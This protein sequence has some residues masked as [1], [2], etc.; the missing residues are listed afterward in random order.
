MT[1]Q[2]IFN[3]VYTHLYKQAQPAL[4][5]SDF[6]DGPAC[7]YRGED[8]AMCA[9]GCLIPDD[10]YTPEI[11]GVGV[12]RLVAREHLVDDTTANGLS[13]ALERSGID[14]YDDSTVGLLVELQGAHDL[15]LFDFGL[16]AWERKMHEIAAA[17]GL[18]V[19]VI[20]GE[21]VEVPEEIK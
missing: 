9:V 12:S 16:A 11:E 21:E 10:V 7:A 3:K 5:H 17:Y 4:R 18:T 2:E 13:T 14:V 1:N 8:G 15:N 20:E 19:P 6:I